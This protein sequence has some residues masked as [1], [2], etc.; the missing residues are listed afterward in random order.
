MVILKRMILK[1]DIS[2]KV[3]RIRPMAKRIRPMAKR[4]RPMEQL[5]RIIKLVIRRIRFM[6]IIRIR[7]IRL[8]LK[9]GVRL[10][11][12]LP[13][14]RLFPKFFLKGYIPCT[15]HIRFFPI[16]SLKGYIQRICLRILEGCIRS[17]IRLRS[18]R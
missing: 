18:S 14:T 7:P 2:T 1:V 16:L 12:Q 15:Y 17:N 6:A 4:I 3:E 5:W 9:V 13:S 11:F 10:I 8:T